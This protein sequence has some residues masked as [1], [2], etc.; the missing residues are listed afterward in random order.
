MDLTPEN[1]E[2]KAALKMLTVHDEQQVIAVEKKAD[3]VFVA[4]KTDKASII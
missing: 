4:N 1:S 3:G 2:Y